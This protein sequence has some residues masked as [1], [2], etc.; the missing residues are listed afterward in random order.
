MP[1]H[2]QFNTDRSIGQAQVRSTVDESRDYTSNSRWRAF[3]IRF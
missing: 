3:Q 1:D 2:S